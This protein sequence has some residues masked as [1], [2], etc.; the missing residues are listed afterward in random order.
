VPFSLRHTPDVEIEAIIDELKLLDERRGQCLEFVV[1]R[2]QQF[3]EINRKI[4]RG[5]K[6]EI[7]RG[8]GHRRK[9][10][11]R[12]HNGVGFNGEIAYT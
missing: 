5:D 7:R 4:V 10:W 3:F 6:L 11:G 2:L 12:G 8:L 1:K 9:P